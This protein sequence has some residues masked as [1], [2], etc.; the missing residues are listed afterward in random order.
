V[1]EARQEGENHTP[2]PNPPRAVAFL[3]AQIGAHAAQRFAERIADLGLTPPDVGLLR[4]IATNP[5]LSQRALATELGVVPSRV[6][7][8]IDSLDSK[9]LVERRRSPTDRR[10]HEL[11]LT[12]AAQQ[13][14]AQMW[15]LAKAHETDLLASLDSDEYQ[16]LATLLERI[17]EQ[18]H[19]APGVHPGYQRIPPS[20]TPK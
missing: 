7:T 19:L 1:T 12:P 14:L 17:A 16:Q 15:Q 3:L 18:Q 9:G 2:P 11:H 4:L 8:L 10:N 13:Q 5:G 20:G 6:V